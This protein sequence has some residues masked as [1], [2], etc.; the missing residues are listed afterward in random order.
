[1]LKGKVK[2]GA[3]DTVEHESISDRFLIRK[4]PALKTFD[5]KNVRE[6]AGERTL[7]SLVENGLALLPK[8]TT[9]A[10]DLLEST[11]NAIDDSLNVV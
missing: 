2:V 3:L 4:I 11:T 10:V 8:E 7:D 1:L 6:Y 9:T 5:G